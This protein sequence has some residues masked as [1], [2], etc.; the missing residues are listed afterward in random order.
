MKKLFCGLLV[1]AMLLTSSFALAEITD[2]EWRAQQTA[3]Q[4]YYVEGIT[5]EEFDALTETT[6]I[7]DEASPTGWYVTFRYEA[8]D[9][10]RVR[11]R[12]E[13]SFSK[14]FE[15]TGEGINYYYP[16]EWTEDMFVMIPDIQGDWPAFEM[17]KNEET[18][19]WS[20]TIPLPTGTWSYRFIEGGVEGAAMTDYTDAYVT[21]DPNNRPFE[22]AE[23]LQTNSQVRVPAGGAGSSDSLALQLPNPDG[24]N[25]VSEIVTYPVT[26]VENVEDGEYEL[27]IYLPY[28]YDAERE[29]PYKVVY[30]SHGAGTEGCTSWYNKGSVAYMLDNLIAQE[31]IEPTVAVIID[32]YNL[33]FDETNLINNILPFVEENYNVSAE[34]SGRALCGLSAGGAY[35]RRTMLS[36]PETFGYWGLFSAAGEGTDVFDA[37]ILG[38]DGIFVG[39]GMEEF[40]H[41]ERA[42]SRFALCYTLGSQGIYFDFWTAHGG[43]QWTIWR[44]CFEAFC[45][46]TL[47][48]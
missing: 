33:N 6:I 3:G 22:L 45:E 24:L 16:E 39:I 26:G 1:L 17:T 32:N 34:K 29:E 28:G 12:G 42:G 40:M 7:K 11:I 31:V 27:C 2:T 30:I 38:N 37:E 48:K 18:G 15:A 10:T 21:V 41:P 13:W 25:G 20:Y 23:G 47:W 14:P 9:A 19:V 4:G 46:M 36:Y 5:Q 44:D 8:P 43:H 35:T